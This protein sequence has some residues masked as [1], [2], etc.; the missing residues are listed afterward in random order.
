[1]STPSNLYAEKVFGEHPLALWPLDDKV[2][3]FSFIS[4][5]KRNFSDSNYWT[6][7]GCSVSESFDVPPKIKGTGTYKI[8]ST[9]ATQI[10]LYAPLLVNEYL[11]RDLN[12]VTLGFY[13]YPKTT[14]ISSISFGYKYD[15]VGQPLYTDDEEITETFEISK[16]DSWQFFSKTF[17]LPEED[18]IPLRIEDEALIIEPGSPTT[19]SLE[20][21][22]FV[23]GDRV[24]LRFD[25][26]APAGL[27]DLTTYYIV[28]VDEYGDT[29]QIEPGLGQGA[30]QFSY[31]QFGNI[32][33]IL[34]KTISP[35]IKINVVSESASESY[36][37]GFSVGQQSEEFLDASLGVE[38]KPLEGID[39]PD[40]YLAIPSKSYGLQDIS[41]YYL[42]REN[43]L[44]SKNSGM[45]MVFGSSDLTYIYPERSGGPSLMF[46]GLGFLNESGRYKTFTIEMWLRI[47]PGTNEAKRIFG[48]TNSDD[49]LY[50]DGSFLILKINDSVG[51]HYIG[52]WYRPM[53]LNIIVFRN[54]A[55]LMI[56]GEKIFDLSF[57]S[58]TIE[59]PA[60]FNFSNNDQDWLA[61]YSYPDINQFE[62]DCVAIYSYRVPSVMAKRRW[63]YGQAIDFPENLLSPYNG[64]SFVAD[65]TFSNYSNNYVYPDIARW[66]QGITENI[67]SKNKVLQPP[68]YSLPEFVFNNQNQNIWEQSLSD[69]Y[70]NGITLRPN[71]AWVDTEGYLFFNSASI[72]QQKTEAFYGVFEQKIGFNSTETLFRLENQVNGNYLDIELHTISQNIEYFSGETIFLPDHGFSNNDIIRF[73]GAVPTGVSLGKEYFVTKIDKNSFSVSESK[74]GNKVFSSSLSENLL[75]VGNVIRYKLKFGAAEEYV[76]YQT[77]TITMGHTFVAG[78]DF[79][80][81][82]NYFGGNLS[83][84][85]SNRNQLRLYAGGNKNFNKTFTGYIYRIG[86]S[87]KRNLAQLNY[88]FDI[89]G[90]PFLRYQF[91]GNGAIYSLGQPEETIDA[92]YVY[93]DYI[94]DIL[95][96]KASYTLTLRSFFGKKYL[97]IATSSYW[98]DYAPLSYFAK[99]YID[100]DGKKKYG[101]DF[102]QF[103][104][105][106]ALSNFFNGNEYDSSYLPIKTYVSF[107]LNEL[108]P[109]KQE[110]SFDNKI[111]ASR[112]RVIHPGS[113]WR[114]TIYEVVNGTVIYPP[115]NIDVNKLSIVVHVDISSEGILKNPARVRSIGLH[116]KTLNAVV[117]NPIGTKGGTQ[118][119]PFK[120]YGFYFE[121]KTPNPYIIYTD[122]TP[123]LYL[124]KSTGLELTGNFGVEDRGISIPINRQR[125]P[126]YSLAAIQFSLR[127]SR[128]DIVL[129]PTQILEI[130][131]NKQED[132]IKIWIKPESFSN[133]RFIVY[134]TDFENNL[135]EMVKFYING[136]ESPN[137]VISL[138]AWNMLGIGLVKEL[139]MFSQ[140][141]RVN[142]VGPVLFNNVS[143]YAL[144]STQNAQRAIVS[145][146]QYL[147]VDLSEV[148][149]VFVGT[150]KT[151][152]G[153]N[154]P[155]FP[156]KYRYSFINDISSRSAIVKPV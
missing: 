140:T 50:V 144:S 109:T 79:V 93:E 61:F 4:E 145:Q 34:L 130:E 23:D 106:T 75:V 137:C 138:N 51:S 142:F 24:K 40:D 104:C 70:S 141:G 92:G 68:D 33:L 36:I 96:H 5:E 13:F 49:G 21:H 38:P 120:R 149:S 11:N 129:G 65:Y 64:E 150:N 73:E 110:E 82:K 20:N 74:D 29:F 37:H 114:N 125:V 135:T 14:N 153:D 111:L 59:L 84:F 85:I 122:S 117:S 25:R 72:L 156:E 35:I 22:G 17:P 136:K 45:P 62:I 43:R 16:H 143:Y 53:L 71:E 77:P 69:S 28:N 155:I 128:E 95:S 44:L 54:G 134:A 18:L 98:Q 91:D 27:N 41:A 121:Y 123:H 12:S 31:P 32:N 119:I 48:P 107:Q 1:M 7:N 9:T 154:L 133:Q 124:T 113:N 47:D 60:K 76:V 112:S 132:K 127:F 100:I 58:E 8:S 90:I 15:S 87:T 10:E 152:V 89:N 52:E 46:P 39:I 42:S 6:P 86:F 99:D 103:S 30:L 147:G 94:N 83:S 102:I 131:N 57:N 2:D 81:L 88:L 26:D 148:Y 115:Q 97:D 67:S 116:S 80:K 151:I 55:S 56:N 19:I 126:I 105:D 146:D 139:E 78:I 118:I 3:Y 101:V 66:T 63:V 108:G